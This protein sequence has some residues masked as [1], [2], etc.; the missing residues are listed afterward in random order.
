MEKQDILD[1]LDSLD[2]Q[3]ARGKIDQNTYNDL[4]KKWLD[5]LQAFE[6]SP[7]PVA[8]GSLITLPAT[9]S[10]PAR[11][12]PACPQCGAPVDSNAMMGNPSQQVQCPYCDYIFA[13]QQMH[14]V[15]TGPATFTSPI[16]SASNGPALKVQELRCTNCGAPTPADIGTM[17]QDLSKPIE[18][19][20]CGSVY[21]LQQSQNDAR[22]NEQALRALL[23]KMGVGSGSM[24][25]SSTVDVESRR[26]IF[27]DKL[28]PTLKKDI[29]RRLENLDNAPEAPVIPFKMTSGFADYQPGPLL[30]S[31]G[32]GDN[33]WLKT[34]S[35]QV[36]ARQMQDFAIEEVDKQSLKT[37]QFR[38]SSLIY[39]AN[40]ARFLSSDETPSYQAVRQNVQTLQQ[41]Y[42]A[43]AQ[44]NL[45]ESYRSY[46]I[47]LDSRMRGDILL[48]DV[49]IPVVEEGRSFAPDAA[50]AQLERAIGQLTTADSQ[51][52]ASTYNL[53]YTVP[54]Q[55]GIQK[56][57]MVARIF[58][59][60][61]KCYQVVL[62]SR[63]VEFNAFYEH[64]LNYT[65]ALTTIQSPSQLLGLLQSIGQLLAA[66]VGVAPVPVLA[67][68]SWLDAVVEG[69]RRKPAFSA[70]ESVGVVVRHYHPYWV[71]T[72]NY[73]EKKGII[74]TVGTGREALILVDATAANAP[75]VG[76]LLVNDPV[77]PT[78]Y[79][80]INTY[81][82]LDKQLMA[83]P[84]LISSDMAV[85]AMKQYTGQKVAELGA[86]TIKLI[87]LIYLPVAFIRYVDKKNQARE[88]LVGR[89][90][91]VN[92]NLGSTLSQTHRFLQQ[93][94]A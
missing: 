16:S 8:T 72:L 36:S 6:V 34:L 35:S 60:I 69:N 90:N 93:Y 47:A 46:L 29:D 78:I 56:D 63:P 44:E 65:R 54:L 52:T 77:L 18:C 71:A 27:H 81:N 2:M 64:L 41:E 91:F 80:G 30:V 40:I 42:Q 3:I 53:Q 22:Q 32:Q 94:G 88:I 25:S 39:Y 66:R 10:L 33:Q 21:M 43:F 73:A 13:S 23:E 15:A 76:H 37:L 75:V 86:T 85:R 58:Q 11:D 68:W 50:L 17:P 74:F 7:I 5:K 1:M 82:L 28:Y 26:Y 62:Q 24:G 67:D 45:D 20:Y 70:P 84:S 79:T 92:Q 83:L 49:L 4:R 14:T 19:A 57:I 51:A 12:V 31:I 48:L 59:A 87:G 89:L 38:L 9:P 61:V 55:E